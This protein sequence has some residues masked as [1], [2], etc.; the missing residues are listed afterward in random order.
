M[1]RGVAY[2]R[3]TSTRLCKVNDSLL[4]IISYNES[5]TSPSLPRRDRHQAM[6]EAL[7]ASDRARVA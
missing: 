2:H 4:A 6:V 1:T 5:M 3:E 7:A